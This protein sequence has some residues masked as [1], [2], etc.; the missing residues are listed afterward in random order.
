[1]IIS[2]CIRGLTCNSY[3]G[4]NWFVGRESVNDHS[5]SYQEIALLRQYLDGGGKLMLS[6]SE[7]AYDL[8]YKNKAKRFFEDYLKA[9]YQRDDARGVKVRSTASTNFG[10][11]NFQVGRKEQGYY[12]ATSLDVIAPVGQGKSVLSYGQGGSAAVGY[13]GKYKSLYFAF[14]LEAISERRHR[15]QLFE[16]AVSYLEGKTMG[17]SIA[18]AHVPPNFS[19]D[20]AIWMNPMPE[21]VAH[22]KLY[23]KEGE[24]VAEQ[25]WKHYGSRATLI[26]TAHLPRASYRYEL[27]LLGQKQRG[28]VKKK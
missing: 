25:E 6:G 24:L 13:D 28:Q 2:L 26:K 23:D 19:K 3:D 20:L 5:L 8:H 17:E 15:L 7:L 16:Q 12:P 14:P 27:N 1:M 21:G 9:S 22:F 11:T 18:I 4:V 10:V